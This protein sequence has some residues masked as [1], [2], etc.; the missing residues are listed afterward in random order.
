MTFTTDIRD[1]S[2]LYTP[3]H[4]QRFESFPFEASDFDKPHKR[5]ISAKDGEGI[6]MIE[7][8]EGSM[9][10]CQ[11]FFFCPS[12]VDGFLFLFCHFLLF[13]CYQLPRA[14]VCLTHSRFVGSQNNHPAQTADARRKR[15][16]SKDAS[17]SKNHTPQRGRQSSVPIPVAPLYLCL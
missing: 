12:D 4:P 5:M 8:G 11:C 7:A 16:V 13:L 1:L 9:A 3:V 6:W 10:R 2:V 14:I 15:S 17:G